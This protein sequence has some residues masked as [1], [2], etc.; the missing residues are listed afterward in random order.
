MIA[1]TMKGLEQLLAMEIKSL[2]GENIRKGVRV[3]YFDGDKELL[4]RVNFQS[5]LALRVLKPFYEF[6]ARDENELYNGAYNIDWSSMLSNEKTFAID[7]VLNSRYFNHSR[8]VALRVKDAIADQFRAKTGK[9]PNVDP[10]DP[11]IRINLHIS[12][13]RCTLL[14]DSSGESLHKRGYREATH[15]APLNEVLAAGIIMLS[16]W[17]RQSPFIDPMCGSGTIPIEAAMMAWNIPPGIYRKQFAFEKWPDFDDGLLGRI[18]NQEHPE[19]DEKPV[20]IG[21][22]ISAGAVGIARTNAGNAFLGK[23]IGFKISSFESLVPPVG[24]GVLVTNPPYGE[25]IKQENL[26]AFHSVMGDVLKNRYPGYTA[27]ILSSNMDA[28]KFTGLRPE[29][30][31]VLFNGALKCRLVKFSIYEGSK[32]H[33]G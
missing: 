30:K 21:S 27:Y 16:G 12:D 23:K 4:Y 33:S 22:D 26:K 6:R 31:T 14:L 19:P 11:D 28:L 25:R 5:R 29:K 20:I 32:K 9:R 2:G 24:H 15:E 3:V 18:Y 7:G 13:D 8:Y 1:K 10:D 17:D